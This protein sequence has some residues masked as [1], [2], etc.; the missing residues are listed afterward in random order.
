MQPVTSQA[1]HGWQ[2]L[3]ADVEGHGD[4]A[5]LILALEK[6]IAPDRRDQYDL[7]WDA[8]EAL[9]KAEEVPCTPTVARLGA[10]PANAAGQPE[11]VG[12]RAQWSE[13][14]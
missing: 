11:S 9:D 10:V 1:L 6:P 3:L 4:R 13:R 2:Q 12:F 8:A 14:D 5:P 7:L